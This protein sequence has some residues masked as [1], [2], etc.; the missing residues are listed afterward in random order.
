MESMTY[1]YSWDPQLEQDWTWTE[2][3]PAQ[4]EI[5]HYIEHVADRHD[6][7]RDIEFE[8]RRHRRGRSTR[9]TGRGRSRPTGDRCIDAVS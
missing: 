1:S 8:T 4:P 2:K 9:T 3:Y 5:L 7:R 6:F